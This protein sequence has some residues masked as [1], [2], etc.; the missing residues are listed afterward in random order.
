VHPFPA[1]HDQQQALALDALREAKAFILV[2]FEEGE[3][4]AHPLCPVVHNHR[5]TSVI[6]SCSH[7]NLHDAMEAIG[8]E[9]LITASIDALMRL[10]P[11]QREQVAAMLRNEE[12]AHFRLDDDEA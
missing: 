10:N 3:E 4:C 9:L 5:K 8:E 7:H 12:G 2:H 1:E 6:A 11:T